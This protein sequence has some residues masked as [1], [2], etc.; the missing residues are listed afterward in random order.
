M[1]QAPEKA[2]VPW[3]RKWLLLPRLTIISENR[4]RRVGAC[5]SNFDDTDWPLQQRTRI[6]ERD[7]VLLLG[8]GR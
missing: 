6:Y 2:K 1:H 3:I 7:A 5:Q 4:R 8:Q